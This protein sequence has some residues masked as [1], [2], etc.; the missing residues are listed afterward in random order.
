MQQQS[1]Y[2]LI[3]IAIL[4][5]ISYSIVMLPWIA[6]TGLSALVIAILLGIAVGNFWHHPSSWSPG[7]QFAA[8]RLLRTAIILYGFRINFQQ[9]ASVGLQA[10]ILDVVVVGSTLILGYY[11]GKKILKLDAELALLISTGAA[12]CGAAAV[13]AVE[14]ILK[15][16]PY[17]ATI[18]IA[19]VVLFGTL[20]MF[21]YPLLQ[22][23]DM[24]DFS[25]YQFGI[26][27]G[28]SIHEVAQ[29]LVAG[30]NISSETGKIAV[31]VKMI[32]VLLLVPILF[33][34][35]I[36][37]KQLSNQSKSK[38]KLIIPWFA[39]GFVLVIGFNSFHLLPIRIVNTIN[40]F[41]II[42]LTMAMAAIG[43]ETKLKKIRQVGLK[44]FYLASILF[45]WLLSSVYF[46]VKTIYVT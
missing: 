16:E 26:F 21:L 2:G 25:N 20:S 5:V 4:A 29:A 18:A 36:F 46:L 28:A 32:R 8:K 22:H 7:I 37:F 40:Q 14:D 31:I 3:F 44:P 11:I 9:I 38:S 1:Y 6:M 23:L 19:T 41:D 33:I 45:A 17:K 43:V 15:S 10:L 13:L 42:L 30:T 39:I 35:A 27:S 34:F 24:F 12:I